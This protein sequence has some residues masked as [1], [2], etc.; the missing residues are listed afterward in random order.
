MNIKCASTLCIFFYCLLLSLIWRWLITK[1]IV[2]R[3]FVV[4]S[5]WPHSQFP[6]QCPFKKL[7]QNIHV[8]SQKLA[9]FW[10]PFIGPTYYSK[11]CWMS[12][13]IVQVLPQKTG[14]SHISAFTHVPVISNFRS[15]C[16][17]LVIKISTTAF[18]CVQQFT[19]I[20]WQFYY[21]FFTT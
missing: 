2:L 10:S 19:V 8:V 12:D 13:V 15:Q 21:K 14:V 9:L 16:I 6:A 5:D 1:T 20:I 17:I 3:I 7:F 18:T 4:L 11:C